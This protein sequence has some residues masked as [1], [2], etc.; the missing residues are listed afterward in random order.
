MPQQTLFYDFHYDFF[1]LIKGLF[2]EGSVILIKGLEKIIRFEVSAWFGCRFFL[3]RALSRILTKRTCLGIWILNFSENLNMIDLFSFS[4][5]LENY[6]FEVDIY[7]RFEKK[8]W[9]TYSRNEAVTKLKYRLS[10]I[11]NTFETCILA[12]EFDKL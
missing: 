11:L 8:P 10:L 2:N 1:I 4:T 6:A 7:G 9:N 5:I 3:S 12:H